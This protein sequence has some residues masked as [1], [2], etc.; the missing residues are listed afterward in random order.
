MLEKVKNRFSK[1]V[2]KT[3]EGNGQGGVNKFIEAN[4]QLSLKRGINPSWNR[5]VND[6]KQGKVTNWRGKL[7]SSTK[8]NLS[9][10]NVKSI[11]KC[12]KGEEN[13]KNIYFEEKGGQFD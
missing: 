13:G 12:I 5:V 4:C 8:L 2:Y 1:K 3:F 9:N 10:I 6:L 11:T 7:L